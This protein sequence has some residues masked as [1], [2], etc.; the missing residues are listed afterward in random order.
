MWQNQ[1]LA[2][3]CPVGSG[4]AS[5]DYEAEEGVIIETIVWLVLMCI[6]LVLRP[7]VDAITKYLSDET[8]GVTNQMP[9]L[10]LVALAIETIPNGVGD[11]L[12]EM[13]ERL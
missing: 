1:V 11:R 4:W 6:N 10:P 13:I 7:S 12:P 2:T 3:L 9:G 5:V 8:L